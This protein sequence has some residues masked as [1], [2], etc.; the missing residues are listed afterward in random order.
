MSVIGKARRAVSGVTSRWF[1]KQMMR[2]HTSIC[3][4]TLRMVFQDEITD[5]KP[6]F[7]H[8]HDAISLP[9][10]AKV[11]EKTGAK[12][13]FDSHELETHR[14]PPLPWIRKWEMV[15]LERRFLPQA[16]AVFTVGRKIADYLEKS[17]DIQRPIVLYNSPRKVPLPLSDRL[18]TW[19]RTNVRDELTVRANTFV[20]TH[21]G[22]VT[23]NRGL[24][25]AVVGLSK[26]AD[27]PEFRREYPGGICLALVGNTTPEVVKSIG[28]LHKKYGQNI[29]IDY[30]KPVGANMIVDYIRTADAAIS[31]GVPLVLSYEFGMPN[32]LFEAVMAGLPILVS[33]LVEQ[34]RFV[35]DHHVGVAYQADDTNDLANR[36]VEMALNLDSYQRAPE[37]QA[38]LEAALS[39]EA[40]EQKIIEVYEALGNDSA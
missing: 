11:A 7:V 18:A 13:L 36:F 19:G 15:R 39:W 12:L 5:W 34:K 21:T 17:Y 30:L 28:R 8:S 24:E 22:N 2:F 1:R 9:M 38:A 27:I 35:Q 10:A 14:N 4:I 40:Q 37:R 32:K 33:D 23:F 3:D 31:C 16:D 29:R 6:D 26:A 20:I 25:Q